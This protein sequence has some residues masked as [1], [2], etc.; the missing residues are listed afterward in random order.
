[1]ARIEGRGRETLTGIHKMVALAWAA[2]AVGLLVRGLGAARAGVSFGPSEGPL[3]FCIAAA[4][5]AGTIVLGAVYGA[6]TAYGFFRDRRVAL[7]WVF[8]LAALAAGWGALFGGFPARAAAGFLALQIA[9]L[10][11]AG[12]CGVALERD[13]HAPSVECGGER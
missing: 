5:A 11:V 7:K 12:A 4:C 9:F 1:V 13:R 10:V 8:T 2:A 3:F 6:F